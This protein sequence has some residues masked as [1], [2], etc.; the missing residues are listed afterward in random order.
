M[1][2]KPTVLVT[3]SSTGIGAVYADR[4]ARRGHNLVLVARDATRMSAL[5]S[6]LRSETGVSVDVVR[7]DLTAPQ[8]LAEV[9]QRVR[10]DASIGILI[11]NAGTAIP[12]S[13]VGQTGDD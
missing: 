1:S 9:E 7:A 6:R 12:G 11:N 4:F 10:E 2:V 8:D 3:G 5:A 13:F